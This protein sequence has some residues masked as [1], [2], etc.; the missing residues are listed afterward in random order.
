MNIASRKTKVTVSMELVDTHAHLGDIK[1]LDE[2]LGRAEEAGVVAVI[3]MGSDRKSNRWVLRESDNYQRAKL[4]IYPAIGLHP[5]GLDPS[6]I[7][8]NVR[9]IEDNVDKAVAIGEIGLDY[10]YKEVRK[11]PEKKEQQ[12][13]LFRRLLETAEK[14]RKPVSIHSRGA[15]AD[16]VDMTMETGIEKAV[17]HWFSGPLDVLEKL[18]D[19]GY[20][21]SA[22]P[23]AAYSK[24]HRSAIKNTPLENLLLETDS[25]VA[26]R[27]E[28][29]EPAH[30]LK[31]LSAVAELKEIT[32]RKAS[33]MTTEN[34]RL[35]F[36]I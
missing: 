14:N 15:W 34:A 13:E 16:C 29:A 20:Y 22:T 24:E 36:K 28:P 18:L 25:P 8:A 2:A 17:F 30:V 6:K 5:W 1:N 35:V 33:E 9:F 23:A 26:Y 7:E 31:T 19:E 32:V 4:K 21:V 10:W 3:T 11:S 27:G 12:R